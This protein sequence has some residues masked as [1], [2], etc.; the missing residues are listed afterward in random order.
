MKRQWRYEAA[1]NARSVNDDIHTVL[2]L[3]DQNLADKIQSGFGIEVAFSTSALAAPAF[4]MAAVDRSVIGSFFVR[5][6]LMLNVEL[7]VRQ[8]TELAGMTTAELHGRANVAV[9]AHT[10]TASGQQQLHPAG[11]IQIQPGDTLVVS[12]VPEFLARLHEMNTSAE[13]G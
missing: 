13:Q 6:S 4:A 5:E 3:F 8:G 9:L 7:T 1:L 2:R 12:T 10:D 11:A